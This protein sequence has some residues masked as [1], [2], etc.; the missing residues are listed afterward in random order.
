[1]KAFQASVFTFKEMAAD[2][3]ISSNVVFIFFFFFLSLRFYFCWT[4][5]VLSVSLIRI[6]CVLGLVQ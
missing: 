1:M 3:Y 4:K 2:C 5:H 6:T